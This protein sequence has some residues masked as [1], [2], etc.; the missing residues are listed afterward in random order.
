MFVYVAC[1][2]PDGMLKDVNRAAAG[3]TGVRR[4]ELVG[5]ALPDLFWWADLPKTLQ[6]VERAVAN[7]R[8]GRVTRQDL[9]VRIAGGTRIVEALHAPIRDS[10]GAVVSVLASAV[11]VTERRRAEREA[12]EARDQLR[13]L[14]EQL[15]TAR[16]EEARR[17]S[18][19]L[20]DELGSVLTVMKWQ[21]DGLSAALAGGGEIDRTDLAARLR[22]LASMAQENIGAVNRLAT[23]LRPGI[24][25]GPGLAAAIA[26]QAREFESRTRL[27]CRVEHALPHIRLREE[28][29]TAV[30]RIVQEA[31]TNILRHSGAAQVVISLAVIGS[32]LQVD[33]ADD[34]RGIDAVGETTTLGILGMKERARVAGGEMEIRRR[35]GH[36]TV[37]TLRIPVRPPLP[38]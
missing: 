23:S 24:V 11:D 8:A 10:T 32:E 27:A 5:R 14:G 17:I 35:P 12:I 7:A 30:Y 20:H 28:Q 22:D 21:L 3:V 19:E 13:A 15:T 37:V 6:L 16:E 38:R 33:V 31:L 2:A 29:G 9:E 25:D 1:F 26:A 36:G 18:R 4:E 34:G